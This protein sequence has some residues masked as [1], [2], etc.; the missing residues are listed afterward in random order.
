MKKFSLIVLVSLLSFGGLSLA[1]TK[2]HN[3][4]NIAINSIE[5]MDVAVTRKTLG[6][7]D[8]IID[9]ANYISKVATQLQKITTDEKT[10]YNIRFVSLVSAT[11]ENGKYVLP[12]NYGFHIDFNGTNGNVNQYYNVKNLYNSISST[13]DN[14]TTWYTNEYSTITSENKK[15]L[16]DIPIIGD[17]KYDLVM[18]VAVTGITEDKLDTVFSIRPYIDIDGT[19][20]YN[21]ESRK[22]SVNNPDGAF[23]EGFEA[24]GVNF[25]VN[26]E[27]AVAKEI[28]YNETFSTLKADKSSKNWYIEASIN[29]VVTDINSGDNSLGWWETLGLGAVDSNGKHF[30]F[31]PA[32]LGTSITE[33]FGLVLEDGSVSKQCRTFTQYNTNDFSLGIWRESNLYHFYLNGLMILTY[34]LSNNEKY[35]VSNA[36]TPALMTRGIGATY[37]NVKVFFDSEVESNLPNT[38]RYTCAYNTAYNTPS[39]VDTSKFTSEGTVTFKASNQDTVS[40]RALAEYN[41]RGD[42]FGFKAHFSGFDRTGGLIAPGIK[43]GELGYSDF[44]SAALFGLFPQNST[45]VLIG[46]RTNAW[47]AART[48]TVNWPGAMSEDFEIEIRWIKSVWYCNFIGYNTDGTVIESGWIKW[49]LTGNGYYGQS[50]KGSIVSP[51]LGSFNNKGTGI[52]SNIVLTTGNNVAVPTNIVKTIS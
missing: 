45:S 37:S 8:E 50:A 15:E 6:V 17:E 31:E 13:V 9:G 19:K 10:T 7:N 40:Y 49:D 18:A 44:G 48:Y 34:D 4:E 43:A 32:T 27:S 21:G 14:V 23:L 47:N 24:E 1:K 42:S 51:I 29:D 11:Y 20:Y 12:G 38:M 33:N 52:V 39:L 2:E 3:S 35:D 36:D 41:Y 16:K 5:N 28:L 22:V 25:E 30:I 46:A 26:K